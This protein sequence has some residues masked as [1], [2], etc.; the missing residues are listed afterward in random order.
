MDAVAAVEGSEVAA[1]Y[2]DF[3][4]QVRR[5]PSRRK[6]LLRVTLFDETS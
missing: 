3:F 5:D 4:S 6:G 2:L 1:E